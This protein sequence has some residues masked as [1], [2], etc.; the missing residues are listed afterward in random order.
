[1]APWTCVRPPLSNGCECS[2]SDSLACREHAG[3]PHALPGTAPFRAA[4]G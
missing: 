2:K 3:K 4:S 1:M